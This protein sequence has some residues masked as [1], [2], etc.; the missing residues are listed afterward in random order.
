MCVDLLEFKIRKQVNF[1]LKIAEAFALD[2][3][4]TPPPA[5]RLFWNLI[6]D[7]IN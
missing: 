6:Q 3:R 2:P 4:P 5:V 7:S 1:V